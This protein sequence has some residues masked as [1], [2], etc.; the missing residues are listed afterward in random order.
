MQDARGSSRSRIIDTLAHKEPDKVP[1]DLGGTKVTG[2]NITA[3]RN[4]LQ[5]K[6]WQELDP[7][8]Q[9]GDVAQQL[10][11]MSEAVLRQLQVDVRGIIPPAGSSWQPVFE[12]I[13]EYSQF[14]DEWQ[15]AWRMPVVGG[16]YYDMAINPLREMTASSE[17]AGFSWPRATDGQRLATVAQRLQTTG[18]NGEYAVT[19]HG[20][21]AGIL[22]M[23]F[24]LRGYDQFFMDL[25]LDPDMAC[26]ILDKVVELKM[27]F[28]DCALNL[29]GDNLDVAVEADDL[30]TQSSLL[31]S[32]TMYRDLIKPRHQRIFNFIK[33]KN[34]RLKVFFHTCGSIFPLIPDLIEAGVDILNPI[35]VAAT[36]MDT[37]QLKKDFGDSLVFWGGAID[38][39][40]TL[41]HG[42]PA[43]VRDEVKQRMDD[44]A[45]GGGFVFTTV[46][47]VQSDVPPENLDAM[48]EAFYSYR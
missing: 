46:H 17:L 24:R 48:L 7:Q 44:L 2:V 29:A 45:P 12:T 22:E 5:Y 18:Q 19:V 42:T 25:A 47:N 20:L 43:Q 8:P 26:G 27:A 41:P 39:Q 33:K 32:P 1:L 23:A 38:T 13:G 11:T 30:G 14:I 9:I 37:K 3:Y 40:N 10:A 35:Q 34:P 4:Y 15:V 28:W 31:L 21:C 6:G 36:G 16:H